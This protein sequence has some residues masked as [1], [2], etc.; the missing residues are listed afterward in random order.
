MSKVYASNLSRDQ[1]EMLND[2]IPA[3]KSG[4]RP[5]SV[6]MWAVLNAMYYVLVEGIRWRALPGDMPPWQTVYGYFRRWRNDGT[7]QRIHDELYPC[8]RMAQG[9]LPTPSEGIIDSQSVKSNAGVHQQVGYDA[10]KRIKGGKRFI[11]V[12]TLGLVLRVFVT[13][14]K[15]GEREGGKTVLTRVKQMGKT[16]TRLHTIWVDGGFD[17]DPFM[18]WVMNVCRWIV[19]VVLRSK[20][21]QGFVLLKKRW[22]VE[23]TFGWFMGCRRLVRDYESLPKTS[24]AFMYLAM[25]RIMVKRLA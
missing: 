14:A 9:R 2:F 22:V 8:A 3:A 18:M 11:T 4:G 23:R 25:I 17:G 21:T 6:D 12:D 10:G 1:F 13:A 20:D 19:Q 7:W 16:A 15:V 24:E 5:R